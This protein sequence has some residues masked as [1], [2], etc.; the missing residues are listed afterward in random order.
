MKPSPSGARPDPKG[1][2]RQD[3]GGDD[4]RPGLAI[5]PAGVLGTILVFA[6]AALC[7]RLGFWQLDRVAER[8]VANAALAARLDAPTVELDRAPDDTTGWT[9]RPVRL[10]GTWREEGRILYAGRNLGG[11][12]GVHVLMPLR[13]AS[14]GAH[15]LVNRGWLPAADGAHPDLSKVGQPG[16]VTVTGLA[17]AFPGGRSPPAAPG[18][19]TPDTAGF[20]RVWF[21]VDAEAIRRQYAFPLGAIAVQLVPDS[22]APP[23]PVRLPAPVPDA[24]PHRGYA[25]QWFSFAAIA[26]LG[27][28]AMVAKSRGPVP[29]R[30][31]PR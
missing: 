23:L 26:L 8:R 10:R 7:V 13:L 4:P 14:T 12:P 16:I 19:R 25:I 18:Y 11:V 24:G 31:R 6:I 29:T 27:W 15:V 5:T 28:A 21:A 3:G 2:P 1:G 17:V 22:A 30:R 20:R 9:F